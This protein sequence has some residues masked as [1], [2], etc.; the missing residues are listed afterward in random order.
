MVRFMRSARVAPGKILEAMS[1]ATEIVDYLK[2]FE[3]HPPL[4]VFVDIFGDITTI[5]WIRDHKDL[6]SLEKVA[7]QLRT[8]QEYL[9]K[10][11]NAGSLFIP[12]SIQDIVMR[13]L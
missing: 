13:S 12:G 4:Q 1:F 11:D 7:N 9:E 10:V 5:R 3:G 8:D 2:K 6:A